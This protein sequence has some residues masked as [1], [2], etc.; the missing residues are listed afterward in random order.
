MQG[1]N[2]HLLWSLAYIAN[3]L[4]NIKYHIWF[5]VPKKTSTEKL[6]V[7]VGWLQIITW[8][9]GVSPYPGAYVCKKIPLKFTAFLHGPFLYGNSIVS[10]FR[11]MGG[12]FSFYLDIPSWEGTYP[13]LIRFWVDDFPN[14]P[15]WDMWLLVEGIYVHL[16]EFL[17]LTSLNTIRSSQTNGRNPEKHRLVNINTPLF[18]KDFIHIKNWCPEFPNT[19][20]HLS[21]IYTI[22]TRGN[23][24]FFPTDAANWSGLQQRRGSVIYIDLWH[25][26]GNGGSVPPHPVYKKGEM[27]KS[28]GKFFFFR[29]VLPAQLFF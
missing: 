5:L 15:R 13:L 22:L 16:T 9:M 29:H 7:L 21:I 28:S 1:S 4:S 23:L 11:P 8:K 3:P 27:N 17:H 19:I 24:I 6:V 12:E 10:T 20:N 14:F 18:T 25:G 2:P 26:A